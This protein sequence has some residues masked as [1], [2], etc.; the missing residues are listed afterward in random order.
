MDTVLSF[1]GDRHHALRLLRALKHRFGST[2]ELGVF[3]MGTGGLQTVPDPSSLFLADRRAGSTGSMVFPSVEGNRSLLVELQAL[4]VSSTLQSPRRAA[5]GLDNGR[6]ALL[7]A[8]AEK[9][10]GLRLGR[11]DVY[12]LAA[13]GLTVGEPASDL[14]MVLALASAHADV[15]LPAD[16][17]AWGELGLAGE[18]RQVSGADRRASEAARMGF[19]RAIVPA[20]TPELD[21]EL[22]LIRCHSIDRAV[23]VAF[24]HH[25][26]PQ[27]PSVVPRPP[28]S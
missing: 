7:A 9:R 1:E 15:P 3:E 20:S 2:R 17:V 18:V 21:V 13:G 19:R 14:P 22:T 24:G 8:M 27:A 11:H 4:V 23:D 25:T 10:A 16:L 5:T 26:P 12:A 6:I 28:T